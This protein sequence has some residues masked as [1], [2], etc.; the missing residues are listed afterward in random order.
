[1]TYFTSVFVQSIPQAC[2][3]VLFGCTFGIF[4]DFLFNCFFYHFLFFVVIFV[5]IVVV[6]FI[7]IF[8]FIISW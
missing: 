6:I 8:I 3:V 2:R 1:M 4:A 5:F 7:F